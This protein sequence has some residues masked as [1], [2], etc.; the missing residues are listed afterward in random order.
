MLDKQQVDQ[1]RQDGFLVV[2]DAFTA[3]S[4]AALREAAAE[5]VADFDMDRHRTVCKTT[6]RD[7]VAI[8]LAPALLRASSAERRSLVVRR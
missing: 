2:E 4:I 6:E 3:A 1:F 5:I 8:T 7:A